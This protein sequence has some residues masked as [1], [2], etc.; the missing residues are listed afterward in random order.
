[1][2]T[3]DQAPS[4]WTNELAI[5]KPYPPGTIDDDWPMFTLNDA[6]IY[7]KDGKTLGNPLLVDKVG[8]MVIRGR[9]EVDEEDSEDVFNA[10]RSIT[11]PKIDRVGLLTATHSGQ[12]QGQIRLHRDHGLNQ[13]FTRIQPVYTLGFRSGRMVR[14][15]TGA[16]IRGS[17]P[18]YP[19]GLDPVLRG[20]GSLPPLPGSPERLEGCKEEGAEKAHR[21]YPR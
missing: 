12:P 21:A 19:P 9:F 14:D 2:A 11:R 8:P 4:S 7:E 5:L 16:T 17:V 20:A 1:M 18:G 10:C 15:P 13:V 3:V 6:V